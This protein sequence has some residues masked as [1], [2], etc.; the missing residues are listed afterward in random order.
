MENKKDIPIIPMYIQNVS[1]LLL[2]AGNEKAK[3]VSKMTLD[4][5]NSDE[6]QNAMK[7]RSKKYME[8]MEKSLWR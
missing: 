1:R 3:R 7:S 6:Y 2:I 5:I 8:A 4:Y